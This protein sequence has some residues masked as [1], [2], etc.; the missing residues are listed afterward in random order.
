MF[1]AGCR[2]LYRLRAGWACGGDVSGAV[3]ARG[4]FTFKAKARAYPV[5]FTRGFRNVF[6]CRRA[7]HRRIGVAA[8]GRGFFHNRRCGGC[9]NRRWLCRCRFDNR[10]YYRSL[11]DRFNNN[12]LCFRLDGCGCRFGSGLSR[13]GGFCGGFGDRK[14]G[15]GNNLR[16][17][18]NRRGDRFRMAGFYLRLLYGGFCLLRDLDSNS[19]C[20]SGIGGWRMREFRCRCFRRRGFCSFDGSRQDNSL[21]CYSL[22]AFRGALLISNV[23]VLYR[24]NRIA[25]PHFS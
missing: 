16:R 17:V 10:L 19:F 11:C 8:C 1:T 9:R 3:G 15:L 18:V 7:G 12:R 2:L 20:R 13:D 23:G 25:D 14:V 6:R 21:V 4:A 24:G 5:T 22:A